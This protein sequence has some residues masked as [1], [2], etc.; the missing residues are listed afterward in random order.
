MYAR[1]FLF[2]ANAYDTKLTH[3]QKESQY[4][5]CENSEPKFKSKVEH[6]LKPTNNSGFFDIAEKVRKSKESVTPIK[7]MKKK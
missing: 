7:N 1:A 3:R 6:Y 5:S 2:L 4:D